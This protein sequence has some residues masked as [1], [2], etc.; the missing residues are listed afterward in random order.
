MSYFGAVFVLDSSYRKAWRHWLLAFVLFSLLA[1]PAVLMSQSVGD[2]MA[3][4]NSLWIIASRVRS[5]K[6]DYPLTWPLVSF[7][8]AIL[9]A[10]VLLSLLWQQRSSFPKLL[11][12]GV[13]WTAVVF[14]WIIFAFVAAHVVSPALLIL[15]PARASDLWTC[16]A[17]TAIASVFAVKVEHAGSAD[18][19]AL[20]IILF[21]ASFLLWQPMMSLCL[22]GLCLLASAVEPVWNYFLGKAPVGRVASFLTLW[23]LVGSLYAFHG[24]KAE[25]HR[26]I[27]RPP[28]AVETIASWAI[29]NSA[30][31]A[32]FLVDPRSDDWDMFRA[33]SKR[34]V[35]T[36]F[37]EG[38][39]INWDRGFAREWVKRLTLLGDD[40]RRQPREE[41]GE[42]YEN[43][44]DENIRT[45][46]TSYR[47]DY[48]VV[49]AEHPS[50][51][52]VAFES[53]GSKVL[54]L[55]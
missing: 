30:R 11:K 42:V 1:L 13:I 32:V 26:F 21:G 44:R 20:A 41:M 48:W 45:V 52:P 2:H 24:R 34:S 40:I 6:H 50:H 18:Q 19:R 15:Q 39:A 10:A 14:M 47:L 28:I 12:H 55:R 25:N 35:Y 16:F 49:R 5:S 38:G 8:R 3:A 37:G 31:D 17:A 43:L 29:S 22:I 46:K 53:H 9:F 4:D 51:F 36:T 33:L 23:V 7:A 27:Q 54:D